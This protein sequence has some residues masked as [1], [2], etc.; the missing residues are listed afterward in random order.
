MS[1]TIPNIPSGGGSDD[2]SQRIAAEQAKMSEQQQAAGQAAQQGAQQAQDQAKSQGEAARSQGEDSQEAAKDQSGGPVG[3]GDHVVRSGECISKIAKDTGHF[4][5]TIWNDPANAELKEVRK[6]PNV[7]MV[8]DRVTIAELRERSED[9]A[10]EQL[11]RFRR[12]GEPAK[13][14]MRLMRE[15]EPPAEEQEDDDDTQDA[16]SPQAEQA[17]QME[18]EP[19]ANV[20]YNL[21]IDGETT[22]GQTDDDGYLEHKMPGNAKRGK[23][24]I[25]PGT[26][27]ETVIPLQLGKLDPITE[28]PGVKQRLYNLGFD[29]G[30]QSEE[31][32]PEFETA[33]KLFQEKHGLEQTGKPD[34]QTRDKLKEVHGS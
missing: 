13:L 26:P 14:K 22:S 17:E 25:E 7:L 1:P 23:L 9:C 34:Q 30:D 12:L 29:C 5:E 33:L 24:T 2:F 4:W 6:D 21:E 15:P 18:D 32:T 8:D 3:Q 19:R 11:H 20:P 16:D 10:T 28:I 27:E 31:M